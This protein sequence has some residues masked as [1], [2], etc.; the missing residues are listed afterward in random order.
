M[1]INIGGIPMKAIKAFQIDDNRTIIR[2]PDSSAGKVIGI[3]N[4]NAQSVE[5]LTE[6]AIHEHLQ[7]SKDKFWLLQ[8]IINSGIFN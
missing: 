1:T 2:M 6:N 8:D 5:I 4:H 7:D 3:V